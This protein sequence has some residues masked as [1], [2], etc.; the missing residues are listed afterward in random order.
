MGKKLFIN[1]ENNKYSKKDLA[2]K[3]NVSEYKI[4]QILNKNELKLWEEKPR[5]LE[6]DKIGNMV[7]VRI[8][9]QF[10]TLKELSVKLNVSLRQVYNLRKEGRIIE[11]IEN[12]NPTVYKQGRPTAIGSNIRQ[13]R[14]TINNNNDTPITSN[15]MWYNIRKS[16]DL[17]RDIFGAANNINLKIFYTTNDGKNYWRNIRITLPRSNILRNSNDIINE[18]NALQKGESIHEPQYNNGGLVSGSDSIDEEVATVN[19]KIFELYYYFK[20]PMGG[21][22]EGRIYK[23]V[24]SDK[25][26]LI[27]YRSKDNNCLFAII[28]H[29]L[30]LNKQNNTLRNECGIEFGKEISLNDLRQIEDTLQVKINVYNENG[31]IIRKSEL[32]GINVLEA[33]VVLALGHYYHI[34]GPKKLT[35]KEINEVK[36]KNENVVKR[37][38]FWDIETIFDINSDFTTV[39]YAVTWKV[40]GKDKVYYETGFNSMDK[41]YEFLSDNIT[42]DE[43][44]SSTEQVSASLRGK[45]IHYKI[46]GF[47][48]SRFDNFPLCHILEKNDNLKEV[49]YVNNSILEIFTNLGHTVFDLARYLPGSLKKNC[50]NFNLVNKK[51]DGFNH[52]I[53][54]LMFDSGKLEEWIKDNKELEQYCKMDVLSLEELF[55]KVNKSIEEI[56]KNI[57]IKNNQGEKID[58]TMYLTSNPTIGCSAYKLWKKIIGGV[59]INYNVPKELNMNKVEY[60]NFI[61]SSMYGGRTQCFMGCKKIEGELKL[62]DVKSLYPFACKSNIYPIGKSIFTKNYVANKQGIYNCIIEQKTS[63]VVYDKMNNFERSKPKIIPLREK[64]KPLNWDY[65]GEIKCVLTNVDIES[66]KTHNFKVEVKDGVYWENSMDIFSKYVSIFEDIKNKHDKWKKEGN[67]EYNCGIREMCKLYLNSLTGK[68]GQR[69]FLNK[70]CILRSDSDNMKVL[71]QLDEDTIIPHTL[72]S[73]LVLITGDLK[74]PIRRPKPA[75][76][77]SFIY[78]YSRKHMYDNILSKYLTYYMDTDSA[79]M[80]LDSYE[81]MKTENKLCKGNEFGVFE[82]EYE[83]EKINIA[84]CIAPKEYSLFNDEKMVKIRAK[85]VRGSDKFMKGILCVS[86]E[87]KRNGVSDEFIDNDELIK[88]LETC[89]VVGSK[90]FYE[91]RLKGEPLSVYTFKISRSLKMDENGVKHFTLKGENIIKHFEA[92]CIIEY[93]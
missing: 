43:V 39:T 51:V 66:L 49:F 8:G 75:H 92:Q 85:G 4:T 29:V 84:Y 15:E 12:K 28:R 68:V 53:P 80:S 35:K 63:E 86:G 89:N 14:Y 3:L 72:G 21:C 7:R 33:N 59:D 81:K 74:D 55:Y 48:S 65:E 82:D 57:D 73:S 34:L 16:L 70:T 40:S 93:D 1:Y 52:E 71:S 18:I 41:F 62:I 69:N 2:L 91:M 64:Y 90:D 79:L 56:T 22:N 54:Q 50:D 17:N 31:D 88:R 42:H 13:I 9:G 20:D 32:C 5:Y 77:I 44:R 45:E 37:N 23:K 6:E 67:S 46:I 25:F 11:A 87:D 27:D 26:E 58:C 83:K 60:D 36:P 19:M 78:S 30:S 24:K 38:L 76:L 10:L 61:R 47:N